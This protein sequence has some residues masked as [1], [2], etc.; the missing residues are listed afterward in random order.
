L[1]KFKI[2]LE[3]LGFDKDDTELDSYVEDLASKIDDKAG[4]G[5]ELQKQL[6]KLQ[7]EFSIAQTELKAERDQREQ[8][9]KQN[10]V[11]TIE[12]KLGKLL[13]DEFYGAPFILKSLI[14]DNQVDLDEAGEIIFKQGDR[15]LDM[16]AGLKWLT[17]TNAEARKNKQNGGAGSP[18]GA[19]PAKTKYTLD[20][21]KSMTQDQI[22]ANLADVNDS[23]KAAKPVQT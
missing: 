5:S 16:K 21:I 12:Q 22:M 2:A 10:K 11:K 14:L 17:D 3:K 1:R 8:L 18:P 23:V 13:S 7:R 9:Q 19:G 6:Q 4:T 20:Q 15:Q